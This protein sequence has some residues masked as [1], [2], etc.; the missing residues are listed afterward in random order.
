M[1]ESGKRRLNRR[2]ALW[3]GL[4][5]L[6]VVTVLSGLIDD[7]SRRYA[8]EAFTRALVTFAVA[9]TLDGVISVAQGTEVAIE[10]GGVGVNVSAGHVLD[11]ITDLGERFSA[12]ILV[13]ITSLWLQY[14]LLR[15]ATWWGARQRPPPIS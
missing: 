2:K 10:P 4:A 6:A 5:V 11:P 1:F 15:V 14:G 9:R 3:S 13:A 8:S 7:T 12:V